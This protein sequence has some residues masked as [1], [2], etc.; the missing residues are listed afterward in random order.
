MNE[1]HNNHLTDAWIQQHMERRKRGKIIGGLLLIAGGS[2]YLAKLFGAPIHPLVFSPGSFL[3]A[4][5]FYLFV[6]SGFQKF[7]GLIVSAVGAAVIGHHLQPE[8]HIM[9]YAIPIIVIGAG[10]FMVLRNI[11][12]TQKKNCMPAGFDKRWKMGLNE[13]STTNE[14]YM[15]ENAIFSGVERTVISK[16]FQGG[17]VSAIM[18]GIKLN[19]LQCDF[20]DKVYLDINCIMG[21]IELYIPTNWVLVNEATTIMGGVDDTRMIVQNTDEH[22]KF[23]VLR[24][25]ILMGGIEIRS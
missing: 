25:T 9:R 23:L 22:K 24:G 15:R 14:N 11:F 17:N 16:E 19:L 18:G 7:G 3:I 12:G 13:D 10:A 2:L 5:G 8:L 4:L 1:K 6:K 21:G 20:A